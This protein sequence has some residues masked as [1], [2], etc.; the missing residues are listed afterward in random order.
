MKKVKC[1]CHCHGGTPG[2]TAM[3]IMP[4]CNNGFKEIAET[5][6]EWLS[7]KQPFLFPPEALDKITRII[8]AWEKYRKEN[9]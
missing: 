3:H 4:C 7:E 8:E 6:A 1:T 5:P 9:L 2:I